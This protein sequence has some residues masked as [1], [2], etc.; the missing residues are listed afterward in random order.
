MNDS[1]NTTH[2]WHDNEIRHKPAWWYT[3]IMLTESC[4]ITVSN[5]FA[6][7]IMC[8]RFSFF[9]AICNI[10]LF[11]FLFSHLTVGLSGIVVFISECFTENEFHQYENRAIVV[12]HFCYIVTYFMMVLVTMDRVLAVKLPF[13]YCKLTKKSCA[14]ALGVSMVTPLMF[15]IQQMTTRKGNVNAYF[16]FIAVSMFMLVCV[17]V[18]NAVIYHSAMKIFRASVHTTVATDPTQH[19]KMVGQLRRRLMKS[20]RTCIFIVFTNILFSLPYGIIT[21]MLLVSDKMDKSEWT[22]TTITVH[23]VCAILANS[24]SLKDPLLYIG[25][26]RSA[27]KEF[28]RVFST[29]TSSYN[30]YNTKATNM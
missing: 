17:S 25:L 2:D 14:C 21:T 16:T 24:N 18:A 13:Y 27:S 1:A 20:T 7:F 10:L 15:L 26:N 22:M 30:S 4:F 12:H 5:I 6:M 28:V 8:R 29:R 19:G 11:C 23:Q 9:D 3:C